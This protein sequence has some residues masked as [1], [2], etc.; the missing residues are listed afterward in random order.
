MYYL[1]SSSFFLPPYYRMRIILASEPHVFPIAHHRVALI[2]L[3][4]VALGIMDLIVVRCS[5]PENLPFFNACE[6]PDERQ[7]KVDQVLS[8]GY[9]V[10]D[11]TFMVGESANHVYHFIGLTTTLATAIWLKKQERIISTESVSVRM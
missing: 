6:K 9:S 8:E 7:L 11:W 4:I 2:I 5:L 1:T 10:N 3:S